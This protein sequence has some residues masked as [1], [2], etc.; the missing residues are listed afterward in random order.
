MQ[1]RTPKNIELDFRQISVLPDLGKV[2]GKVQ[3]SLHKDTLRIKE[4]QGSEG[5]ST[6]SALINI[7]QTWFNDTDNRPEGKKA[8]HSLF[9]DS[10][11]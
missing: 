10:V 7:T 3:V 8:I 4:N 11:Q 2:L 5:R 6:V 9:I 1:T